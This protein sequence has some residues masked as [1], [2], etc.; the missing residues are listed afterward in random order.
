[1][2]D[3]GAV[4]VSWWDRF[5]IGIAPKWGLERV[6][7][8]AKVDLLAR[9]FNAAQGGRRTDQWYR[10]ISDANAANGPAIASLRELARDLRRNNGWAKRGVQAIVNNTVGWGIMA[11]PAN[12]SQARADKALSVWNE[13]ATSTACDYDGRLDFYG[14]QRLVMECIAESGECLIIKQPAASSDGLSIPMRIHVVEPDYIDTNRNGIVGELG[15][16]IIDGVEFDKLG[17]RVAYW[18]YTVHPGSQRLWT[19]K[20]QSIRTP[21][22]R[23]LHIYRVDRPGQIR[24][25]SWL[26]STITRLKDYDD[27]ED[28][29]LMQQKVAAC[30]GAFVTDVDG[31]A[32]AVGD[33]SAN[34][35]GIEDLQPGHVA[36]LKPG[37]NVAFATP[38]VAQ[39]AQF[40]ER[41]LRRIAVGLG[42]TY[43]D[44]TGDYSQVNFSS[45]RMARL[46]HWANVTEWREH[47]LIPQM[48]NG[49]WDWAMEEAAA[50]Y[51]W[52]SIPQARWSAPPMPILEPDK[53]GLALQR[54]VR[55]GFLTWPQ[56]IRQLGEDPQEQ[57]AEIKSFNDDVDDA[58]IVLDCDPR[59]VNQV[60]MAQIA[61]G[62]GDDEEDADAPAHAAKAPAATA[63]DD[64]DTDADEEDD[65]GATPAAAAVG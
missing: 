62:S 19:Q 13:W 29:E 27:F 63:A 61:A 5:L 45:A 49:V 9:H 65:E 32:P 22:D 34:I 18:L 43:E 3:R 4:R 12:R 26:A 60:G 48:C 42:V 39:N 11:K 2:I 1:M 53:E 21:A 51:N 47:M 33:T 57:L 23:V 59:R 38:P 44:L 10:T 30:F 14:L 8:R 50:L 37:Q 24:G 6:R 20:F 16:P 40:S 56:A 15:G 58:E 28:A 35:A 41:T 64:D 55:G 54:L 52:P 25:V 46:A 36:Y 7:A 31:T 17:R